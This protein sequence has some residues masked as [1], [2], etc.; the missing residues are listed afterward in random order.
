VDDLKLQRR[1]TMSLPWLQDILHG[2][3]ANLAARQQVL[4]TC[5]D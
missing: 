5:G 2:C 3:E 1:A 4:A